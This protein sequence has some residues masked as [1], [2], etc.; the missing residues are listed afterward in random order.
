M[1]RHLATLRV[2]RSPV[3]LA[4]TL[5]GVAARTEGASGD[6][7][8][9]GGARWEH[10]IAVHG[11]LAVVGSPWREGFRGSA[12]VFERRRGEWVRTGILQP[13]DLGARDHFG[14]AVAIQGDA[15]LVGAPWHD[16]LRGAVYA[17]RSVNGKWTL[18]E[19]RRDPEGAMDR[20]FGSDLGAGSSG[21]RNRATSQED[22]LALTALLDADLGPAP[23][24]VIADADTLEWVSASDGTFE[25]RVEVKWSAIDRDAIL[26]KILRDGAL[27][28]VASSEDSAYSDTT[29]A[30]GTIYQYCVVV[31]EMDG[32]ESTPRCDSGSRSMR[33]PARLS[34][35]DGHFI[36]RVHLTWE[37]RSAVEEGFRVRRDGVLIASVPRN[38][39]FYADTSAAPLVQYGYSVTGFDADG[40]ESASAVDGGFRGVV[41]PPLEV[42]ASDG[43]YADS[44]RV[45]WIDQSVEVGFIVTRTSLAT[46]GTV[47]LDTTA[48]GVQEFFDGTAQHGV[49][50]LYCVSALDALGRVSIPVCDEGVVD[51]LPPAEVMASDSTFD[52]RIQVTWKDSTGIANGYI[53]LRGG[54]PLDTLAA[55]K[56]TFNDYEAS[57]NTTHNY[58]VVA[59]SE[60][61]GQ[62]ASGCD[63]GFRMI[64]LAPTNVIATDGDFEN[65]TQ[66]TWESGSTTA[67]VF[68]VFRDGVFIKSV[69]AGTRAYG[70]DGGTAGR[71]YRYGVQAMTGQLQPSS[72]AADTGW[73]ALRTPINVVATDDEFEDRVEISWRDVSANEGG[74]IVYRARDGSPPDSIG[75][76]GSGAT[77]FVDRTGE[78]GV[79]YDYSVAAFDVQG[80]SLGESDRSDADEGVRT[81]FGPS[82]VD[83]TD[84]SFEDRVEITWTDHSNVEDGYRLFRDGVPITSTTDNVT[85]AFDLN[86]PFGARSRYSVRAFDAHGTS[87]ADSDSGST[88]LLA[89]ATLNASDTYADRIELRWVDVSEVEHGYHLRTDSAG[90]TIRVDTLA[91]NATGF[92][93]PLALPGVP[94][95]YSLSAF[96]GAASSTV[97]SD[98]GIRP[99]QTAPV[100][101]QTPLQRL[102]ADDAG[103]QTGSFGDS[104]GASVAISDDFLM[105]VGAYT[106]DDRGAFAGAAYVFELGTD[107]AWKQEAKLYNAGPAASDFF[108]TS[109]AIDGNWAAVGAPGD[110]TRQG[111]VMF[112]QQRVDGL[113]AASPKVLANPRSANS[114]FGAA[115]DLDG[116]RAI[117]G[118]PDHSSNAG[119]VYIFDRNGDT[120]TQTTILSSGDGTTRSFGFSVSL[121]GDWAIVGSRAGGTA[122]FFRRDSTT[123][124]W[125]QFVKLTDPDPQATGTFGTSVSISGTRAAIGRLTD[126]CFEEGP[127]AAYVFEYDRYANAWLE[128]TRLVSR[129]STLCGFGRTV[130][131]SDDRVV[132]GTGAPGYGG[133]EGY[134]FFPTHLFIRGDDGAWIERERFLAGRTFDGEAVAVSRGGVVLGSRGEEDQ[135]V[136]SGA[137]Y[138]SEMRNPDQ[139][140]A[141]DGTFEGLVHIEWQDRSRGEEGF[142]IYR[143]G[144]EYANV[145]A[146]EE[147]F[148][149]TQAQP[150]RT[151]QYSVATVSGATGLLSDPVSDFGWR[152]PNGHITGRVTARTGGGVGGV[153]VCLEPPPARALLFDGR[154]GHVRIP[155]D[156]T[157]NFS[158]ANDFSIEVWFSYSG[159]ERS[160]RLISKPPE[161]GFL[162]RPLD[163]GLQRNGRL[164]SVL[165]DGTNVARTVSQRSDLNDDA[166]HH[167]VCVHDAD[168]REL[169]LYVDG[170]EEARVSTAALGDLTN[171]QDVFLGGFESSTWFGGRLDELRIWDTARTPAEIAETGSRP[172]SRSEAGLIGYWPLDEF[173]GQVITDYAGVP[174]YGVLVGGIYRTDQ[175]APLDICGV[176]DGDGGF[177]LSNV[178][179]EENGTDYKL[180]PSL[181]KRQFSPA[182]QPITLNRGH[183]V[184]NQVVFSDIST[185]AVGGEV[186]F[187]GTQC[188][189]PDVEILVDG[190]VGAVSD[191]NGQFSVSVTEGTHSLRARHRDYTYHVAFEG[192][193]L[194]AD[195]ITI[196][197]EAGI[198]DL[199]FIN[200]TTYTVSGRAGG[201]CDRY[202]GDI[203]IRYRSEN[204]CIDTTFAGNPDYTIDLPPMRYFASATIDRE[205]IPSTLPRPDVIAFFQDL[206]ER[207]VNLVADTDSTILDDRLDFVYRAPLQVTIEGLESYVPTGCAQLQ[208]EDGT[209]LPA[210]LPILAQGSDSLHLVLRVEEVYGNVT[211][212]L[213][214]GMVIVI[215]EIGDR[216]N[217][218]DTLTVLDGEAV[219][220]TFPTT[221]SLV[222]GRTEGTTDRS[223]Q[224]ALTVRAVVD[225]RAP[226]TE[227]AWALVTG[228]V[229]PAGSEFITSPSTPLPLFV[230]RDPPGDGSYGFIEKGA[231]TCGRISWSKG[232]IKGS[233]GPTVKLEFGATQKVWVGVGGGTIE[234][235]KAHTQFDF[236]A[237]FGGKGSWDATYD[238]CVKISEEFKTSAE[239]DFIGGRGDVYVGLGMN[240]LFAEVGVLSIAGCTLEQSTAIGFEPDGFGTTF[241]FTE[242]HIVETLIPELTSKIEY[243]ESQGDA[244]SAEVFRR[245]RE[246]WDRQVA[247][248]RSDKARLVDTLVTVITPID[249]TEVIQP[250]R[251]YN[252]SF[253]GGTEYQYSRETENKWEWDNQAFFTIDAETQ[254]VG[255]FGLGKKIEATVGVAIEFGREVLVDFEPGDHGDSSRTWKVGYVLDDDD[256]GDSYTVDVIEHPFWGDVFN[257]VGGRSSCP[258]EPWLDRES[259]EPQMVKRDDPTLLI[260]PDTRFG[261]PED[262]P[263]V[264]KLAI[265][266]QSD[267]Q[268]DYVVRLLSHTNPGGALVKVNGNPIINKPVFTIDGR[269][270]GNVNVHEATLTVERGPRRLN[271]ENLTLVV[272]PVCGGD[273]HIEKA[274]EWTSDTLKFSVS[275][276][277]CSD[278]ALRGPDVESGWI[279]DHADSLAGKQLDVVL[280][281]YELIVDPRIPN[282]VEAVGIQYRYLGV[283]REGLGP[284]VDIK[285]SPPGIVAD[286]SL[287]GSPDTILTWRPDSLANGA[288][289]AL[290][291]GIYEL[292]AYTVCTTGGRGHSESTTGTIDRHAPVVFGKPEPADGEL[293]LGEVIRVKFNEP[294]DCSGV[295]S[296]NVTLRY[297]DGPNAGQTIAVAAVCNGEAIVLVPQVD[298]V[299]LDG[300]RLEASVQGVVDAVGNAMTS[301]TSWQF[302]YRQSLL[303]WTET[304]LTRDVPLVTPGSVTAEVVNGTSETIDYEVTGT[305]SFLTVVAADVRGRLVPGGRM[306]IELIVDPLITGGVHRGQVTIQ[307][308]NTAGTDTVAVAVMEVVLNVACL[309]PAWA[310]DAGD[311][312]YNMS[313]VARVG[314]VGGTLTGPGDRV[315]AFVGDQVRGVASPE[316][317][318]GDTL[319]FLTIF[320]NRVTGETVRFEVWDDDRCRRYPSTAERVPFLADQ[321]VGTTLVPATLTAL[322][323]PPPSV[324]AF[325]LES[326][327]NWF[328]T[329]LLSSDMSVGSVLSGLAPSEGDI[330][331]SK[332][333]FAVF[334]PDT[335][336]GWVGSL[337][338]LNNTSGYMIR[339]ADAGTLLQD[340][341]F[342][343]PSATSVP[344]ANGWNWIGYLP[345]NA[346]GVGPALVNLA[347]LGFLN[348]DEVIKGQ[349]SFAEWNSGW[350][351]SLDTMEPGKGYRLFLADPALPGSFQYPGNTAPVTAPSFQVRNAAM[352]TQTQD[353][354][355]PFD[356]AQFEFNMTLILTVRNSG[357]ASWGSGVVVGAFVGDECRGVATLAEVPGLAHPRAFATV[358]GR[359]P[360]GEVV[361]FR[362]YDPSTESSYDIQE[363]IPF[364]ADAASGTLREPVPLRT[365]PA[366][367][368]SRPTSFSLAQ[369]QPNPFGPTTMIRFALPVSDH[370]TIK[371]YDVR[372][373]HVRTLVDR[374]LEAGFHD[375]IWDGRSSSGR[376]VASG[377]YFYRLDAGSFTDRKKMIL[378]RR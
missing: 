286:F 158:V 143:D 132:V 211:C 230:L 362:A 3:L 253:S 191:R 228:H 151:Y 47:V 43:E 331:K 175:G 225:G 134:E 15:I 329:N 67:T 187:A 34:A 356:P 50:Y 307:A 359:V 160:P 84:G 83:A 344:I 193:T 368:S 65:R 358:H 46:P 128:Q 370:V 108:G 103:Q 199:V 56:R 148:D 219:Y 74:H 301:S 317:V 172:V 28:S 92:T 337:T 260:D 171:G 201:G 221:P 256:T 169:I 246:S 248:N 202:V 176:T 282:V 266:N 324:A 98:I 323:T 273:P 51:L 285:E 80:E 63:V 95:R 272:E 319:V 326:G 298:P 306:A 300:R 9:T 86:P 241:A 90:V 243:F 4:L 270:G 239:E 247:Y 336:V 371:V 289:K 367:R 112:F 140:T 68:R 369:N 150:G 213:D 279:Y 284:W 99:L 353:A 149:D 182:V 20:R 66:V 146:D 156:G 240:F 109:A 322:D 71:R 245:I 209:L 207:P 198:R 251:Q 5:L 101:G 197:V 347:T 26:L 23:P 345:R 93:D 250:R 325:D 332:T 254:L 343:D 18:Q 192:D 185:H 276:G 293:S 137:V 115:I 212:P 76:T 167:V 313:M 113:W 62:S 16:R 157:F 2:F 236:K 237:L 78:P 294:L 174:Q 33:P 296:A 340:G 181:G 349:A 281:G 278:I 116:S 287:D 7:D 297:L 200:R 311:F 206:G 107:G 139:V 110:D 302:D 152:P 27:I 233:I 244:D 194:G 52:D 162:Q 96:A 351:G 1:A 17:F 94:Y 37:D 82:G 138:V 119:R 249:S 64:V 217:S 361:S 314:I 165:S 238:I 274:D 166:W 104:F 242:R 315:V 81:L 348:G 350:F 268:R 127:A 125:S 44:V 255:N 342:V 129:D 196:D 309:A 312:E 6:H 377:V 232:E 85:S 141:S 91:A 32:S 133:D 291:D 41:L 25:D 290:K 321:V 339:L 38:Q 145:D 168:S 234:E 295:G 70:D 69:G 195:S 164:F 210:G 231:T 214:S 283:D 252:R 124:A 205:S 8:R 215:D 218:P 87:V 126:K 277:G 352:A 258:Y 264:F 117:I 114:R 89:P 338:H 121:D 59:F 147:F 30:R 220:T 271:Y 208:L 123:G 374:Q 372:G 163:L 378:L 189:E 49:R 42:S 227:R 180:R 226:K 135:G 105:V 316:G 72:T 173:S 40:N 204:N 328:S 216:E 184:E 35:S 288:F 364:L 97:A 45:A 55:S 360:D 106:D 330:I 376:Q 203:R 261:V 299:T 333:A 48:A 320:S 31:L 120:W 144:V 334:D 188:L 280:D 363:T 102:Q 11:D 375:A 357:D 183:P 365:N 310:V 159:S 122:F 142:I 100:T 354:V 170:A 257:V 292:R 190:S 136:R 111:S 10:S 130:S 224:K 229:A 223:F 88:T 19:K 222:R 305:P 275:F 12:H 308:V 39:R 58:C 61:G 79:T 14:A 73:R 57:P 267:E 22:A 153:S 21:P 346:N 186:L 263:A 13:V 178:R 355:W 24:R 29:G 366:P 304:R 54:T 259:G 303:T 118:A 269:G 179:Y 161:R 154:G 131:I 177:V 235:V 262:Q 327:W 373:Q 155:D 335:S 53:V 36:D 75:Q 318:A 341:V 60:R 77:S 265:A